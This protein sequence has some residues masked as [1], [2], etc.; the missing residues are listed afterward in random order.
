MR[1]GVLRD[2]GGHAAELDRAGPAL[3][4]GDV[5]VMDLPRFYLSPFCLP[6]AV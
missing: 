4:W 2:S 1:S 5:C 3:S 6:A